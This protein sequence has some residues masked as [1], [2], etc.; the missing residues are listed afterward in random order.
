MGIR[1]NLYYVFVE[2][3]FG[4]T[5]QKFEGGSDEYE[6]TLLGP[7]DMKAISASKIFDR[8]ETE[9]YL[10]D[11]LKRGPKCLGVR[12]LGEIVAFTWYDLKQCDFCGHIFPL[13][14]AEACLFD[15]YTLKSHRG[16]GIAPYVRYQ[17][18]KTLSKIGRKRLLSSSD[19]FNTSA[20]RFKKKLDA[21]L[22][23]LR[24]SV[25]F[26]GIHLDLRLKKYA[27]Q[28]SNFKILHLRCWIKGYKLVKI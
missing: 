17:V 10:L 4:R 14:E 11:R 23:E 8:K 19:F 2:G 16:K 9:E 25:K 28:L 6:I 27:K 15:A 5:Q 18:Y 20:I 22:L 7:Q 26:R 24:L 12:C 21:K 13:Q 1:I 3:L